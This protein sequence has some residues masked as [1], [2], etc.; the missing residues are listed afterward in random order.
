MGAAAELA[1]Q[2]WE[3]AGASVTAKGVDETAL[4]QAIFGPATGTSRGSRSTSTAPTSWS[5]SSGPGLADG[6]TNFSG[7][8]NADYAAGWRRRAR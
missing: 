2:Q 5:R 6:G 8:D 7:I 1:V 3:A 4:Q